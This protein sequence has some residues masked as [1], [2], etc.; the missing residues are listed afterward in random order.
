MD[1]EFER[2]SELSAGLTA[3]LTGDD[4]GDAHPGEAADGLQ[5]LV[6]QAF[7]VEQLPRDSGARSRLVEEGGVRFIKAASYRLTL[8]DLPPM[9]RRREGIEQ[10][11]PQMVKFAFTFCELPPSRSY[12]EVRVRITLKPVL[13]VLQLRP[14]LKNA[15]SQ[16]T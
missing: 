12:A 3:F 1:G 15:D 11:R 14:Y 16:S 8:Y 9:A 13:S 6:T 2:G 5:E 7:V 4:W 10:S